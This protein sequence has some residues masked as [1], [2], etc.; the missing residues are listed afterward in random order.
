MVSN[1][2]DVTEKIDLASLCLTAHECKMGGILFPLK[3]CYYDWI[4]WYMLLII[5]F[6][7][8]SHITEAQ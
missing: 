6:D 4:K 1:W 5:T 8:A 3:K 2:L 7:K